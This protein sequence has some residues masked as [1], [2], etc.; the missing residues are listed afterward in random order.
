MEGHGIVFIRYNGFLQLIRTIIIQDLS[1]RT[2]HHI[3]VCNHRE[4]GRKC[5]GNAVLTECHRQIFCVGKI[6]SGEIAHLNIR[7]AVSAGARIAFV[8]E[9]QPT[10]CIEC[11][12]VS[13]PFAVPQ[14]GVR[15]SIGDQR[16]T[17]ILQHGDRPICRQSV[18]CLRSGGTDGQ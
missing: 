5:G 9:V 4:F 8:G 16:G 11:R 7:A 13:P 18:G 6:V 14:L 3:R 10:G 17:E 1:T 12:L 15:F 2:Q